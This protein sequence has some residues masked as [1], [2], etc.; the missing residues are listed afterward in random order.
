[1]WKINSYDDGSIFEPAVLD[2]TEA[3]MLA[4]FQAG[5]NNV[6]AVSL[7]A[8]YPT[9]VSIPHSFINGYKNVLS[10]AISTEYTFP[11]AKKVKDFL[12]DPEAIRRA[13]AAAAAPAASSGA[14]SA[15]AAAPAP[16]PEKEEEEEVAAFDL[17]D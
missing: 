4:K 12:S 9:L 6:A 5:L 13:A 11:L 10:I 1:L 7:A 3:D 17:F 16:E 15:S 14:A 2:I 8:H